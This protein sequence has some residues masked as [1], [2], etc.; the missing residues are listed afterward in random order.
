MRQPH[1]FSQALKAAKRSLPSKQ[2]ASRAHL[3]CYANAGPSLRSPAAEISADDCSTTRSLSPMTVS[4][5]DRGGMNPLSN[6]EART[7]STNDR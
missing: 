2:H 3:A 4:L 1:Y 5:S 7:H 6:H